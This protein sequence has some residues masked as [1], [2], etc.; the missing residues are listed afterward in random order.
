MPEDT[1][2]PG[3]SGADD[4]KKDDVV[5][6]PGS[7]VDWKKNAEEL[8]AKLDT[9]TMEA[10]TAAADSDRNIRRQ[11]SSLQAQINQ[12][13]R[14]ADDVET[15]WQDKY[16]QERMSGMEEVDALRYESTLLA[17]ELKA[18]RTETAQIRESAEQARSA[19]G[20]IQHFS[21]LGINVDRLNTSGS[22]Q[23]LA[24]SGYA[25][26]RE[27]RTAEGVKMADYATQVDK[28]QETVAALQ[29]GEP[30]PNKL[31]TD[32]GDLKPPDVATPGVTQVTGTRTMV[33]ALEAA[34]QYFGGNTPTEEM[35]YRAVETKQL[36]AS[37]L[38]GLEGM[39]RE[40]EVAKS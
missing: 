34:K 36:P 10:K 18:S 11:S 22:L 35:L 15:G 33:E 3:V 23:D 4:L 25:A 38:P 16:H 2:L 31:A 13:N 7:E 1:R 26:E 19:A 39:P 8:Q 32:Q 12:A 6:E 37:V 9:A 5:G 20:Y 14:R 30:D 24:D 27:D 29:K 28:L 21:S 17:D 40:D